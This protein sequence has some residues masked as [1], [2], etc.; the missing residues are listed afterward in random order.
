MQCLVCKKEFTPKNK[1]VSQRFCSKQCI[2]NRRKQL[3]VYL[4]KIIIKTCKVCNKEFTQIGV[5]TRLYCSEKCRVQKI[6]EIRRAKTQKKL[7]LKNCVYCGIEF[8][9]RRIDNIY[10]SEKCATKM[11]YKKHREE[12]IDRTIVNIGIRKQKTMVQS[13]DTK[14]KKK[15]RSYRLLLLK[16]L[17]GR[18]VICGIDIPEVLA[19]HHVIPQGYNRP[20]DGM[21][22]RTYYEDY[23]K[24]KLLR[25]LC[26]NH[27]ILL[28]RGKL[29]DNLHE[30]LFTKT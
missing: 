29:N 3:G 6:N 8:Q 10:C 19:I 9:Q 5:T 20:T 30:I 17:G 13:E 26:A 24:G 11:F 14:I 18:C 27:H 7:G 2:S 21:R 1:L 16:L 4:K 28:H 22:Y 15:D 23:K 25:L 12:I